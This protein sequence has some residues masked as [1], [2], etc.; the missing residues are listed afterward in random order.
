MIH[1]ISMWSFFYRHCM[2]LRLAIVCFTDG[3]LIYAED[4]GQ[5]VARRWTCSWMDPW[6]KCRGHK[7]VHGEVKPKN[8]LLRTGIGPW[9]YKNSH[10][11]NQGILPSKQSFSQNRAENWAGL[12]QLWTTKG[13]TL[14]Q[15]A[16]GITNPAC[17]ALVRNPRGGRTSRSCSEQ[18]FIFCSHD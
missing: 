18:N 10:Y 2:R 9:E 13:N 11:P 4:S 17:N 7:S 6:C 14:S 16:R 3:S 5:N 12:W 8:G 1:Y 15:N